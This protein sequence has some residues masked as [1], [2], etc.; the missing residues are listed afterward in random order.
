VNIPGVFFH[1]LYKESRVKQKDAGIP[2]PARFHKPCGVF[3]AG[4]FPERRNLEAVKQGLS[5][6][7]V[8]VACAGPAGLDAEGD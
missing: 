3:P 4:L 8:T 2:K 7:N 5:G 6:G 1:F